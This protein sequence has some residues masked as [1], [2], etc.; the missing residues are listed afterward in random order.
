VVLAVTN[1]HQPL[2]D[3]TKSLTGSW[4]CVSLKSLWLDLFIAQVLS[5]GPHHAVVGVNV[6]VEGI[7]E[8]NIEEINISRMYITDCR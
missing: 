8:R 7:N 3:V 4:R 1:I 5:F 2:Q 6:R